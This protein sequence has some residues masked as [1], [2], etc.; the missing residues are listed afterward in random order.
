MLPMRVSGTSETG[1]RRYYD[2]LLKRINR[3]SLSANGEVSIVS[4]KIKL[5]EKRTELSSLEFALKYS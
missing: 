1:S 2:S 3:C 4:S 5:K